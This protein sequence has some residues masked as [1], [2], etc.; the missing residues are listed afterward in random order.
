MFTNY[1]KKRNKINQ[2]FFC[3]Y[4]RDMRALGGSVCMGSISWSADKASSI[5][6]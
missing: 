6:L 5:V 3:T 2:K 4:T 1:A